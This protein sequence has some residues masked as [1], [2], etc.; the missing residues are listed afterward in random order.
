MLKTKKG[1][2]LFF[3]IT[4]ITAIVAIVL[5]NFLLK[6][7]E[8]TMVKQNFDSY[9]DMYLRADNKENDVIVDN[10]DHYYQ[11]IIEHSGLSTET[12]QEL[13]LYR[14]IN[15]TLMVIQDDISQNLA[16]TYRSNT[17]NREANQVSKI[18]NN[19][20]NMF[21]NFYSYCDNNLKP[22]FTIEISN[23]D[24]NYYAEKFLEKYKEITNANLE[25]F[26]AIKDVINNSVIKGFGVNEYSCLF[27]TLT[28]DACYVVKDDFSLST[29][30]AILTLANSDAFSK[31]TFTQNDIDSLKDE[32]EIFKSQE[33]V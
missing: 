6:E 13:Y 2:I 9:I 24:I 18:Y 19:N 26:N 23:E 4:I 29:G 17:Y 21:E 7:P 11:K 14:N 32:Y 22:L 28:V 27:T 33:E 3:T 16:F 20:I 31:Y 10:S 12:K 15:Y 8:L 25:M 5:I 30:L 1:R